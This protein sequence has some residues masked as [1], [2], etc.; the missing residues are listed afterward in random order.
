MSYNGT[1]S[2]KLKVFRRFGKK[3]FSFFRVCWMLGRTRIISG[4]T[5]HPAHSE[6]ENGDSFRNVGKPSHV[7]AAVCQGKFHLKEEIFVKKQFGKCQQTI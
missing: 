7:D 1:A 6:D 4:S 2:V 5:K 3:S